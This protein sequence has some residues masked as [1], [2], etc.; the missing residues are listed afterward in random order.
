[1]LKWIRQGRGWGL[2]DLI[3]RVET[4]G[5]GAEAPAQLYRAVRDAVGDGPLDDDL[6]S[7]FGYLV[8]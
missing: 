8:R 1:M 4:L 6:A 2:D 7:V 3:P 5:P